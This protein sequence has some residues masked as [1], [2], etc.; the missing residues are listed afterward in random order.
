MRD[1]EKFSG[2]VRALDGGDFLVID[3]RWPRNPRFIVPR[4]FQHIVRMWARCRG[5]MGA[6]SWPDPGA[7]NQQAAWIV[8]AFGVLDAADR[9]VDEIEKERAA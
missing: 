3:E 2:G 1:P 6:A 5:G 4:V 9:R 7:L 8:A